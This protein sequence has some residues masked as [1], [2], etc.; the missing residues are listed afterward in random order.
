[1]LAAHALR[2]RDRRLPLSDV[3]LGEPPA[4]ALARQWERGHY[5]LSRRCCTPASTRSGFLL[6][7][8]VRAAKEDVCERL[9]RA[10]NMTSFFFSTCL[11]SCVCFISLVCRVRDCFVNSVS[12]LCASPSSVSTRYGC[13]KCVSGN[14]LAPNSEAGAAMAGGGFLHDTP[15]GQAIVCSHVCVCVDGCYSPNRQTNK[16]PRRASTSSGDTRPVSRTGLG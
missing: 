2:T 7:R 8:M 9:P 13:W 15:R 5:P 11:G 6:F 1:M 12:R 16:Q 14:L 10:G 4:L 3:L